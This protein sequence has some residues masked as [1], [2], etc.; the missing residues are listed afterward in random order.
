MDRTNKET[1]FNLI[2]QG[3]KLPE[4]DMMDIFYLFELVE[5]QTVVYADDV[6]WL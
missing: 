5:V 6:P 2:K 4:I 3:Y 1:W